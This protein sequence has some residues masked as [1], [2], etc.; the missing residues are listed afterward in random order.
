[1]LQ[2]SDPYHNDPF[3]VED[4]A[5][6]KHTT[7]FSTRPKQGNIMFTDEKNVGKDRNRLQ[8]LQ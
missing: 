6:M 8:K 2:H 5:N 1:M 4:L 7:D 3:L